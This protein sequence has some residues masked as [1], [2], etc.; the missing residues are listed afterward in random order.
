MKCSSVEGSHDWVGMYI[1]M[2]NEM[3]VTQCHSQISAI[4]YKLI[5][6]R[7]ALLQII[8]YEISNKDTYWCAW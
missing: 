5:R 4:V 7:Y 3:I 8:V 1:Y 2:I 6:P